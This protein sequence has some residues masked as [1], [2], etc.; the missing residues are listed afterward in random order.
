MKALLRLGFALGIAPLVLCPPGLG[1]ESPGAFDGLRLDPAFLAGLIEEAR[2]NHPALRAAAR[3]QAAAEHAVTGVRVWEDPM[4][5]FG[6]FV[7]NDPGPDLEM[8]GDLLFEVEQKLPLFGKARAMRKEAEAGLALSAAEAAYRFQILRRSIAQA[9]YQLAF[10]DETLLIGA[11]D[12]ALVDRMSAFARERQR[13]GLDSN[14]DLLRLE[15][16]RE[17]RQQQLETDRLQREFA[18]VTLNRVLG[19]P[20]E[21]PWPVLQNPGVAP[22]VPLSEQLFELGIRF[23]PR[24]RILRQ[25]TAMADAGIEIA[26][27]SRLPDVSLGVEGRQWSGS[28]DFREGMFTVGLNL[29]WFNRGKY[30]ADL[31][32]SRARA[33]AARAEADDYELDVR[34]ELFRVWSRIDASRREAILYQDRI[35]PRARLA[36]ETSLAAWAAGRG[37]FLDVLETRRMLVEARLMRARAVNEQQQMIADLVTCCGVGELDSLLMLGASSE[38]PAPPPAPP[39]SP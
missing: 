25:D 31:D 20:Q 13:A 28:G 6:G 17:K 18:R 19:R 29:P 33:D 8:E 37:L 12:L 7:A 22:A 39:E 14:L 3:R 4:F 38:S 26:R 24:L 9:A 30:R 1:S 16:E 2:T 23:E 10:A 21:T 11:D 35:L 27:R 15:N 34:Q 36:A 32:R 5:R